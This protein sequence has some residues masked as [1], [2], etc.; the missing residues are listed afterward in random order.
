MKFLEPTICNSFISHSRHLLDS[1]S[2]WESHQFSPSLYIIAL[3]LLGLSAIIFTG[4]VA[5]VLKKHNKT[6]IVT[7]WFIYCLSISD[8]IVGVSGL[9]Y[10]SL[11]LF[12]Y[13][14]STNS[15]LLSLCTAAF[16]F[17]H[18]ILSTSGH[19]ILIIAIDRCIHMTYLNKYTL[20]MTH[21][22]A[23]LTKLLNVIV[24]MVLETL[25]LLASSKYMAWF[26]L[27]INI[28]DT[29]V[30]LLTLF[31]CAVAYFSIRRRLATL[32]F[33]KPQHT[34]YQKTSNQNSPCAHQSSNTHGFRKY[35]G[36][37]SPVD[38][39]ENNAP[40]K[41]VKASNTVGFEESQSSL[42]DFA[43]TNSAYL[44][45]RNEYTND[46]ENTPKISDFVSQ[47]T[48][49]SFSKAKVDKQKKIASK[50]SMKTRS[51]AAPKSDRPKPRVQ[52]EFL[53]ATCLILLALLISYLPAV[54]YHYYSFAT[55]FANATFL[56]I[57]TGSVLLNSSLNAIV[58]VGYSKE[59]RDYIRKIV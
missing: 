37:M 42:P 33:R 56:F 15:I 32:H 36:R 8:V 59:I 14:D 22:R 40:R 34:V 13:L 26:H 30:M 31:I 52:Q 51:N 24:S 28:L 6:S 7:F 49:N 47:G 58:L 12:L 53:K 50:Q 54:V 9:A 17:L 29:F 44:G 21:F 11:L 2:D 43:M 55:R 1:M 45:D 20:F 27:S 3:M 5:Y 46:K 4:L 25:P 16:E 41:V 57:S 19:F 48:I 39:A 35:A 10:Q 18:Y 23:R 38:E